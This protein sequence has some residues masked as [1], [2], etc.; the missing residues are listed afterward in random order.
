MSIDDDELVER[1]A[2]AIYATVGSPLTDAVPWWK[3]LPAEAKAFL[4][5]QACA[6]ITAYEADAVALNGSGEKAGRDML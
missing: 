3:D 6:A 4:R 2:R 1:V 5:K